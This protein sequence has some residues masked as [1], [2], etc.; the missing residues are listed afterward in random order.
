MK[1]IQTKQSRTLATLVVITLISIATYANTTIKGRVLNNSNQPVEFAT[2]TIISPN[3]MTV[4]EGD[5]CNDNGD[6]FIENVAPGEYILSVRQV[7]FDKDETR[8]IKVNNQHE[9][10]DVNTVYLKEVNVE[11]KELEVVGSSSQTTTK[12]KNS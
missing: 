2:A 6:F 4:I 7:G 1:T 11:L 5:M 8:K 9:I 12:H 3:S 10:V